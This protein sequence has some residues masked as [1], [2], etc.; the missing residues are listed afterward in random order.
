MP[1][2]ELETFL[3]QLVWLVITF[4]FIY[5]VMAKFA[6]PRVGEI[7]EER[8]N[9]LDGD[10]EQAESY[11][12]ESE[13]LEA[14]YD[15]L[16]AQARMEARTHLKAMRKKLDAGLA[17]KRTD[18][19]AKMDK[20]FAAAEANITAARNEV[21]DDLEKIASDACISIV[22][23]LSGQKL[24]ATEAGKAVKANLLGRT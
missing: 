11:K 14:D 6:L 3:P 12:A 2:L 18:M 20:K 24:S 8:Q 17:E 22:A 13:K 7:L 16:T 21:L 5:F 1:Q 9:R 4:G 15:R 23:K 10:L 19:S